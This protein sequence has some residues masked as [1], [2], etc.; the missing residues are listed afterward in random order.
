MPMQES[1]MVE[2]CTSIFQVTSTKHNISIPELNRL[3]ISA[4]PT[5]Q[6]QTHLDPLNH[7]QQRHPI[8][9]VRSQNGNPVL[10]VPS[11]VPY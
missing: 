8:F 10:A 6:I 2:P 11:L 1:K 9:E 4:K 5:K 3:L 7:M